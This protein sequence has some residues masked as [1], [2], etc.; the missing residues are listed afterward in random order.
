MDESVQESSVGAYTASRF[1]LHTRRMSN[2]CFIDHD[3]CFE[4]EAMLEPNMFFKTQKGFKRFLNAHIHT[5]TNIYIYMI[6]MYI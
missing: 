3:L 1:Q 6:F 2:T 4:C 5:H